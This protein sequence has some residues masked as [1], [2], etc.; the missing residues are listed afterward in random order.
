MGRVVFI[1]DDDSDDREFFCDALHEI[2]EEIQCICAGNGNEAMALL[3]EQ[4]GVH[5]DY[6]FLDMNMPRIS[7]KQCLSFIKNNQQ[8]S[9]I[10][11]IIFSTTRQYEEAEEARQLGAALFL[12]KPATYSELKRNLSLILLNAYDEISVE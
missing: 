10:P 2:D 7:G 11:V 12:T 6:I 3:T 5:P 9:H 1:V 4:N 8:L